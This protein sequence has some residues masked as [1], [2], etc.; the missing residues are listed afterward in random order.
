VCVTLQL[1]FG[2]SIVLELSVLLSC[3]QQRAGWSVESAMM[4][5]QISIREEST[6]K[7]NKQS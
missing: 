2:E 1:A 4:D 6:T 7:Y 3:D 5:I